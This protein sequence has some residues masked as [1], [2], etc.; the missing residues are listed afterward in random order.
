MVLLK[1]DVFLWV[2]GQ[3]INFRSELAALTLKFLFFFLLYFSVIGRYGNAE[4][5]IF[6][7]VCGGLFFSYKHKAPEFVDT[8]R[9]AET[10]SLMEGPRLVRLELNMAFVGVDAP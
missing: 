3:R 9:L 8:E 2:L 7:D 1:C 10:L 5:K 4:S 6:F